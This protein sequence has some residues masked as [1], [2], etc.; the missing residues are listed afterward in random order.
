MSQHH[1]AHRSDDPPVIERAPLEIAAGQSPPSPAVSKHAPEFTG[2]SKYDNLINCI[3][4]IVF[5]N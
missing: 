2:R 1:I 3:D 5:I 4:K